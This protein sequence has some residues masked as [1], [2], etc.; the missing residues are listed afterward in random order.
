MAYSFAAAFRTEPVLTY[1]RD[2]LGSDYLKVFD[3]DW[4]PK[5]ALNLAASDWQTLGAIAALSEQ[6]LA[7]KRPAAVRRQQCLGR[8]RQP[9]PKRQAVAGG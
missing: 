1:V 8:Q 5:G 2:R 9:Y 4:Q 3:L 6:A 7:D